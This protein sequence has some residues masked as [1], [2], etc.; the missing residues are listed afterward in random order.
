MAKRSRRGQKRCPNCKFW[1]KGTRAKACPKCSYDF[2]KK[3]APKP[4]PAEKPVKAGDVITIEQVKAVAKTVKAVGGFARLNELLG[5]I[6]EV[7]GMKKFKDL[8]EALAAIEV[9]PISS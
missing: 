9:D 4:A 1:I 3:Q 6:R 8:L 5:L 2:V 7:G